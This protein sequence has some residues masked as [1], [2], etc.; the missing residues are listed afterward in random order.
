[1]RPL[2]SGTGTKASQ[3]PGQLLPLG[4]MRALK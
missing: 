4:A 2:V 1:M 3:R